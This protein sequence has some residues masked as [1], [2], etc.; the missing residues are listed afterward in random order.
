MIDRKKKGKLNLN[1]IIEGCE[2][3]QRLGVEQNLGNRSTVYFIFFNPSSL[4]TCGFFFQIQNPFGCWESWGINSF[5]SSLSSFFEFGVCNRAIWLYL[6][7]LS[8]SCFIWLFFVCVCV[9]VCVGFRFVNNWNPI[10]KIHFLNFLNFLGNQIVDHLVSYLIPL[11]SCC[12]AITV[13]MGILVIL[14][15]G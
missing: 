9:C 12:W 6:V 11:F 7:R 13:F 2:I 5:Y 4:C 3:E 1:V 15:I 8:R 10:F 14:I